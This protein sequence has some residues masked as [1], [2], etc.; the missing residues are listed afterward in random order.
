MALKNFFRAFSLSLAVVMS[1]MVER[2]NYKKKKNT[3]PA[4]TR[5]YRPRLT[6]SAAAS[7]MTGFSFPRKLR[8][9]LA[10]ARD[11]EPEEL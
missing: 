1:D 5:N 8:S 9:R 6:T 10:A 2:N 11:V 3:S 7:A 4:E